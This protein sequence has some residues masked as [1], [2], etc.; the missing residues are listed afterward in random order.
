MGGKYRMDSSSIEKK[1]LSQAF[2]LCES[3]IEQTDETDFMYM[4]MFFKEYPI[5]KTLKHFIQKVLPK[6]YIIS[7]RD[8]KFFLENT[9]YFGNLEKYVRNFQSRMENIKNIWTSE[10]FQ[11]SHDVLWEFFDVFISLSEQYIKS[12]SLTR[13]QEFGF[14]LIKKKVL[15]SD[16]MVHILS[17]KNPHVAMILAI[18]NS[19]KNN[20]RK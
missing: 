13:L 18:E 15:T 11:E 1:F 14:W 2:R 12:F 4:K 7:A 6:K 8:D 19:E 20:L 9:D 3:M 16:E 5:E 17:D 10:D